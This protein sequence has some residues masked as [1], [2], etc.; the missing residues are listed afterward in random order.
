MNSFQHGI[1][2]LGFPPSSRQLP[3]GAAAPCWRPCRAPHLLFPARAPPP[4]P[5]AARASSASARACAAPSSTCCGGSRRASSGRAE[6]RRFSLQRAHRRPL[7]CAHLLRAPRLLPVRAR[8]PSPARRG[9][10]HLQRACR[11]SSPL[12]PPPVVPCTHDPISAPC[13]LDTVSAAPPSP[14]AG[15]QRPLSPSTF[16]P[17]RAT[18]PGRHATTGGAV[19]GAWGLPA[20]GWGPATPVG[21]SSPLQAAPWPLLLWRMWFPRGLP[22][23]RTLLRQFH[24]RWS[25]IHLRSLISRLH[26]S[27]TRDTPS[28]PSLLPVRSTRCDRPAC[29][30]QPS[31]GSAS[32]RPPTLSLLKLSLQ[33]SSS[34]HLRST[35]AGPPPL[36]PWAV[37]TASRPHRPSEP[38][39]APSPR[40]FGMTRLTR[41][42]L[43]STFRLGVSRTFTSWFLSSWSQS[44]RPTHAGGTYSSSPFV[45]RSG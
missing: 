17:L 41:L 35:T 27:P 23:R 21:P 38:A 2:G 18:S 4:S 31:C 22:V 6:L 32:A 20:W 24:R 43:S 33:N 44:R 15:E 40:C 45:L 37:C 1:R 7:L 8:A 29:G 3:A 16:P 28:P 14:M 11:R 34:L 9:G 42:W 39:P 25:S 26:R 5:R 12:F 13:A 19:T 36:T 10:Q 30:K